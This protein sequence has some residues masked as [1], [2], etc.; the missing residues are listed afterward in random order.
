[1]FGYLYALFEYLNNENPNCSTHAVT[2]RVWLQIQ[3]GHM[4]PGITAI[5]LYCLIL[6]LLNNKACMLEILLEMDNSNWVDRC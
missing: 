6:L 5:N 1:M 2:N 3:S 4:L